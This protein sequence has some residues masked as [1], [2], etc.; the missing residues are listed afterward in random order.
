MAK[1]WDQASGKLPPRN[2]IE[3]AA[4]SS[5]CERGED[6]EDA[7]ESGGDRGDRGGFGDGEPRPHIEEG[8]QVAVGFA[9]VDV[10]AA[11]GGHHGAELGVGHRA[12]EREQAADDPCQINHR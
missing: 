6:G 11:S 8:G 10:F 4:P 12:E 5:Q 2:G 1:S 7:G 3:I 9:E